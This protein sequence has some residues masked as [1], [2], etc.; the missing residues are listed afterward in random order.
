LRLATRGVG[1]A[2]WWPVWTLTE[3]LLLQQ[4]GISEL[5]LLGPALAKVE[6]RQVFYQ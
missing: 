3:L 1:E 6:R 5:L 2:A 4:A